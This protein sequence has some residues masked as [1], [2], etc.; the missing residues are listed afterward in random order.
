[1]PESRYGWSLNGPLPTLE[2]HSIAKHEIL[3]AYLAAYVQTLLSNPNRD[4]FKLTLVDGFCGGGSYVLAD[5]RAERPGSPLIMLDAMREAEALVNISRERRIRFDVDYFFID[6]D[7]ETV[8]VLNRTLIARQYGAQIGKSIHLWH[9]DFNTKS[10]A[11]IEHVK[12][13]MPLNGRAIFLLDQ[14]GYT[15]VPAETI[16][17]IMTQ[18]P[19]AEVILT[20]N[21]SSLLTYITDKDG[22]AEALLA[23]AGTPGC[24]RGRSIEDIK[25][26]Q[27]DWRL[28]IQACLYPDL[29]QRCGARF[30]TLF[31]IRSEA[32]HGDYWFIHLS[33]HAR[34]RDVMTRIHWDKGNFF[35]HYGGAGLDMFEGIGYAPSLDSRVSNQAGLGFEF[36][37]RERDDSIAALMEQIPRLVYSAP[38]EGLVFDEMFAT[39]CN[40]SPA[41]AEIHKEAVARLRDLQ[42]LEVVRPSKKRVT[43]A[44]IQ[45]SDLIRRPAQ[46]W[47]K[48]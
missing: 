6:E 1:M 39:H 14:Y 34:A 5:T 36:G 37:T 40:L 17:S 47:M 4:E 8:A 23:S 15:D 27:G 2:H 18:V 41:H 45:G 10:A 25:R 21:V 7:A 42:E 20:F 32:G 19:S 24:L 31:F 26:N 3:R 30:Y 29:I 43:T 9:S 13:R 16:R 48:L 11:L 35:I 28:F 12:R 38:G 33:Q 22:R 44:K 46:T